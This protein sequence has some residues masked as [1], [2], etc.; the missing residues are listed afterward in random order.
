M[1]VGSTY[2]ASIE[3]PAG[4]V[5]VSVSHLWKWHLRTP[6]LPARSFCGRTYEEAEG[7]LVAALASRVPTFAPGSGD[8]VSSAHEL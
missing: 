2:E 8:M 4:S 5:Q 3:T 1:I 6:E 7:K